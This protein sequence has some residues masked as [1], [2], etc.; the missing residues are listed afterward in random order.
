MCPMSV[1][2]QVQNLRYFEEYIF[3]KVFVFYLL[4]SAVL[5]GR[6]RLVSTCIIN[7]MTSRTDA[8]VS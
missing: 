2:D 7:W 1:P 3:A 4:A 5:W 8:A 6:E